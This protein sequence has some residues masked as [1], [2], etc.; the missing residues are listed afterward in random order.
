MALYNYLTANRWTFFDSVFHCS[1]KGVVYTGGKK[2][3]E[4]T[5][6]QRGKERSR[7]GE[8]TKHSDAYIHHH[9]L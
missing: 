2:K 4:M 3:Q 9:S 1:I 8:E 6:E 5:T 7:G